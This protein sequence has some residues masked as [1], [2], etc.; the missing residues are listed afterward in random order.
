MEYVRKDKVMTL[1]RNSLPTEELSSALLYQGV[2][3]MESEDVVPVKHGKWI[4]MGKDRLNRWMCSECG[5]R[6]MHIFD[7]CPDCGT[8]MDEKDDAND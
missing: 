6:E 5:R 7:Y 1:V 2:K 8:L 4:D 3:Q